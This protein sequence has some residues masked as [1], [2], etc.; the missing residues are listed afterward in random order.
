MAPRDSGD[1]KAETPVER[2]KG[3]ATLAELR[4][5][6]SF[7]LFDSR[8]ET[9]RLNANYLPRIG[10]KVFAEKVSE[11]SPNFIYPL[12]VVIVT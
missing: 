5:V 12:C 4:Y 10:V 2:E 1:D 3:F 9:K 7:D 8:L 6:T 11:I